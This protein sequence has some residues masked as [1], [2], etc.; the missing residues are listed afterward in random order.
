VGNGTG[1]HALTRAAGEDGRAKAQGLPEPECAF[2][3]F[4][5]ALRDRLVTY[6]EVRNMKHMPKL[7]SVTSCNPGAGVSSVAA[8]LAASLSETGEGKVLLVDMAGGPG[9]A[10]AFFHGKA[11]CGLEE[12]LQEDSRPNAL[13]SGNLYAVSGSIEASQN[14]KLDRIIPRQFGSFMPKLKASDYEYIIFDMPPVGQTSVTAKVARFMDMVLMVVEADK[15]GREVAT[16]AHAL[17]AES[18]GTVA[19]VLNKRRRYVPAWLLQE[20]E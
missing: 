17:L 11:A 9:T 12:A 1:S 19:T 10:H 13:V 16:R 14:Q 5:E 7:I 15:T 3:P 18:R 2:K 6:F 8:G 20:F 4:H